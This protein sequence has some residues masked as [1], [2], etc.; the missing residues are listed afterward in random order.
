ME[1]LLSGLT[2][3]EHERIINLLTAP[4]QPWSLFI[5]SNDREIANK[6]DRV[7]LMRD[8]Q[9]IHDLPQEEARFL[10]DFQSIVRP[11]ESPASVFQLSNQ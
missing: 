6:T 9:I 1:D 7:I 8:G 2:Q 5:I 10:A 4:E 11:A 3:G